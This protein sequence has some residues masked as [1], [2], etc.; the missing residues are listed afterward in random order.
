MKLAKT[1]LALAALAG[2]AF[3]C[4]LLVGISDLP[5]LVDAGVDAASDALDPP[6]VLVKS[7]KIDIL[8]AID[9]SRS[10]GD[11]QA[12]LAKAIP[13]FVD[14]L[15]QGTVLDIHIGVVSSSLGGG[16]AESLLATS[17]PIC[18]ANEPDPLHHVYDSHGD[19]LGH[20]IY[21]TKP[22]ADAGDFEAGPR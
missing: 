3:A 19:D 7:D 13:T 20:L 11:K 4:N 6:D 15:V 21:R 2:G 22:L 18:P 9:N 1:A 12:L 14:G 8:F 17:Q 10:M 5:P 16:G